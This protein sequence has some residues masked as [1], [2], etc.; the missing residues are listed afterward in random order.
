MKKIIVL[1]LLLFSSVGFSQ[2]KGMFSYDPLLNLENFDSEVI[3][4]DKPVVVD[5]FAT[6]CGPCKRMKPNLEQFASATED[7]K[8]VLAD[9]DGLQDILP[10]YDVVSVPTIVLFH[11]G[12]EVR[13]KSGYMSV[14]DLESF[15]VI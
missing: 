5:F 14:E 13:R 3:K 6:W 9:V 8:V 10:N 15:S 4:S 11:E 2:T 1:F 12:K 7:V